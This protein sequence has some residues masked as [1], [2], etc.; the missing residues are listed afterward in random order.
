MYFVELKW[1]NGYSLFTP[2]PLILKLK[3]AIVLH[4]VTYY[5]TLQQKKAH[6]DYT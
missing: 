4:T 6:L 1:Y 5:P 3:A 2:L